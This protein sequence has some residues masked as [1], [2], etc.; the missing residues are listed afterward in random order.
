MNVLIIIILKK[1]WVTSGWQQDTIANLLTHTSPLPPCT[2]THT[3]PPPLQVVKLFKGIVAV[4]TLGFVFAVAFLVAGGIFWCCRC[5]GKCGGERRQDDLD[6]MGLLTIVSVIVLLL[7]T[8][9]VL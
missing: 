4:T 2:H 9:I 1:K 8:S 3:T 6:H 5:C 7:F